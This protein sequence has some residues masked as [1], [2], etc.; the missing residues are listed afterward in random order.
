MENGTILLCYFASGEEDIATRYEGHKNQILEQAGG[1]KLNFLRATEENFIAQI[2]NADVLYM[3][4]GTNHRLRETLEKYPDFLE[5]IKGKTVVGSSAGA[6]VLSTYYFSNSRD[7][8]F[9]GLGVLPIRLVCHYGSDKFPIKNDPLGLMKKYPENLEL[10][11]LKDFEWKVF[12][13]D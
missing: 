7:G 4:G 12:T 10:V 1:K 5:V 2:K 6:N 8:I 9:E 13:L 3:N 11:V